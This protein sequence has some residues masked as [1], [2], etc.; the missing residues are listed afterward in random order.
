MF[1]AL[2]LGFVAQSASYLLTQA[3][4][5]QLR[6]LCQQAYYNPYNRDAIHQQITATIYNAFNNAPVYEH[7]QMA[8]NLLSTLVNYPVQAAQL[9]L[10]SPQECARRYPI[11]APIIYAVAD[12]LIPGWRQLQPTSSYLP[13]TGAYGIQP[14]AETAAFSQPYSLPVASPVASPTYLAPSPWIPYGQPA[15][16]PQ[17]AFVAQEPPAIQVSLPVRPASP[18]NAPKPAQTPSYAPA[19]A[20]QPATVPKLAAEAAKKGKLLNVDFP[21]GPTR[22]RSAV[23]IP[24]K[25]P[26]DHPQPSPNAFDLPFDLEAYKAKTPEQKR[27]F[28]EQMLGDAVKRGADLDRKMEKIL[29]PRGGQGLGL[30]QG[31]GSGIKSPVEKRKDELQRELFEMSKQRDNFLRGA[32]NVLDNPGINAAELGNV[33]GPLR[34]Q[35]RDMIGDGIVEQLDAVL[36]EEARKE[37]KRD[38]FDGLSSL[39]KDEKE[40][41]IEGNS[42][43]Q[44]EVDEVR[45]AATW[46]TGDPD[47]EGEEARLECESIISNGESDCPNEEWNEDDDPPAAVNI[48]ARLRS[49]RLHSRWTEAQQYVESLTTEERAHPEVALELGRTLFAQGWVRKAFDAVDVSWFRWRDSWPDQASLNAL[50]LLSAFLDVVC[51]YKVKEALET[52]LTVRKIDEDLG[53]A[54][55]FSPVEVIV[56]FLP[57]HFQIN[58]HERN[59]VD[60]WAN[61]SLM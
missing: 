33:V 9:R 28:K 3:F 55:N 2:L 42:Q 40:E 35:I 58:G 60:I 20:A 57:F 27:A 22:P 12:I 43:E 41:L 44:Y 11:Y 36:A 18:Y 13:L 19:K 59:K 30:G 39:R 53:N 4:V 49:D 15:S 47:K 45:A 1:N 26:S 52:A 48:A 21:L 7:E 23:P 6:V 8:S 17:P 24:S 32:V 34:N 46:S 25:S 14:R 38:S 5:N 37:R 31:S 61:E 10:L 29:K 51:N 54:E 16:S 50:R 56:D